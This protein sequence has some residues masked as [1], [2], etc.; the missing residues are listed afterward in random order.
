MKSLL[1]GMVVYDLSLHIYQ[2]ITHKYLF[3]FAPG[4]YD[5]FWTLYWGLFLVLLIIEFRRQRKWKQL[6]D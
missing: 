5:I 2:L 6:K 4:A 3:T 1:I